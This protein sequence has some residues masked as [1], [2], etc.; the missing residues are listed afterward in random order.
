MKKSFTLFILS[1]VFILPS[2]ANNTC[3]EENLTN[4]SKICAHQHEHH[5]D[6]KNERTDH[7]E[8]EDH[9]HICH[10]LCCLNFAPLV[11][12]VSINAI[13]YQKL[14]LCF[15]MAEDKNPIDYKNGPFR[16]PIFS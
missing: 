13:D 3:C 1:F 8:G 7:K 6:H 2:L 14:H 12:I 15:P 11:Y 5:Q 4:K 16:P 10:A 9:K